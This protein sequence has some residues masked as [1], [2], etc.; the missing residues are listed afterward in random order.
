MSNISFINEEIYKRDR[1]GEKYS[2]IGTKSWEKE[3]DCYG[4]NY[5]GE[6]AKG[7]F[8]KEKGYKVAAMFSMED[9]DRW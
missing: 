1:I 9:K 8:F 6:H 4:K 2:D 7:S 5:D 3:I